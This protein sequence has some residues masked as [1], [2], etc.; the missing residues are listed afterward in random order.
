MRR[1]R[2]LLP[3]AIVAAAVFA[4]AGVPS[5]VEA[6]DTTNCFS[7]IDGWYEGQ[8]VH[9]DYWSLGNTLKGSM[10]HGTDEPGACAQH[11]AYSV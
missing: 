4:A 11:Q 2:K 6:A 8:A 9:M 10:H 7:C 1:S 5:V 3:V